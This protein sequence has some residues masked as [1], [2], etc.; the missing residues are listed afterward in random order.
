MAIVIHI[1]CD[2]MYEANDLLRRF[3]QASDERA[4]PRATLTQQEVLH[5]E[6]DEA[7]E[8]VREVLKQDA[9]PAAE[10]ATPRK[11]RT[12]AEIE[13]AEKAA[14]LIESEKKNAAASVDAAKG[15]TGVTTPAGGTLAKPV[16]DD[17]ALT[18]PRQ[19][20]R[21]YIAD[22]MSKGMSTE[23][24]KAKLFAPAGV[25]KIPDMTVVQL[26]DAID[27]AEKLIAG[28]TVKQAADVFA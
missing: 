22:L 11:R 17:P 4:A 14:A 7:E 16:G 15:G 26:G 28:Y 13:A 27:A 6:P 19:K 1:E 5:P 2:H 24:V 9:A 3:N 20:L 23:D 21:G 12:K 8:G 10:V 18:E 25:T